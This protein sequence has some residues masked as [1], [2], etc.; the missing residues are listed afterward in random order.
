MELILSIRADEGLLYA[1]YS[2][3]FSL[4]EAEST[5]L[6]IFKVLEHHKVQ[7]VVVDGRAIT[8]EPSTIERF[9]YG[10]FVA[11]TYSKLRRRTMC[12]SPRFAY[13]LLPPVLD[14]QRLGEKVAVNRGM[15]GKAFDNLNEALEWLGIDLDNEAVWRDG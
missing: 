1:I 13:V 12:H 11:A 9:L 10:E 3:E 4:A 14:P 7:N 2:G 15:F 6:Q 5:F 8:G